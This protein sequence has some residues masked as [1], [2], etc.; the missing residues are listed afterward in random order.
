[1]EK[2]KRA[3]H[4]RKRR[5]FSDLIGYWFGDT[6]SDSKVRRT[7]S[8]YF[9]SGYNYGI[10]AMSFRLESA[11]FWRMKCRN[12]LTHFI[13][14]AIFRH[15]APQTTRGYGV[16]LP[17]EWHATEFWANTIFSPLPLPTIIT[18]WGCKN[19]YK[20]KKE[21]RYLSY[22]LSRWTILFRLYS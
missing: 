2:C 3:T 6:L 13:P 10:K 12:L 8:P 11:V 22:S 19:T 14:V 4:L 21:S 9:L 7:F 16:A 20:N 18:E 1:M 17:P 15:S 5:H